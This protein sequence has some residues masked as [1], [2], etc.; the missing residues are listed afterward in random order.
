MANPAATAAP[1][2]SAMPA[3]MDHSAHTEVAGTEVAGHGAEPELLGLEPFQWVSLAMATLLLIAFGYAKVHRTIARGLD[4][5]IAQIKQNLE[6]AKALRAEAEA[7]RAEYAAK[8]AGAEQDAEAL[9]G[10][11][12]TEADLIVKKAETDATAT[13][14][15]REQ[16]AT[17]K[18][19]AAERAAVDDL[20][21]QAAKASAAGAAS[22]IAD[23]HDAA[24]DKALVDQA[25]SAL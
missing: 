23:R 13:I 8:I 7:L 17:D 9:L 20:R 1:A 6:E 22:L 25:I 4:G 14:A 2:S 5:K 18:I 12:R 11:A 16:M 15:R 3:E 19:A 10:N 21:A 24:A